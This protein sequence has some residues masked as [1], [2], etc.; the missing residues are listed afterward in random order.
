MTKLEA[1]KITFNERTYTFGVHEVDV[2]CA[3]CKITPYTLATLTVDFDGSGAI[4]AL[5]TDE[6]HV[7]GRL[8]Q[9][10]HYLTSFRPFTDVTFVI[11]SGA[12]G[13][14]TFW[15]RIFLECFP[16]LGGN[17]RFSMKYC[18]LFGLWSSHITA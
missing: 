17:G 4:P 3:F 7:S 15:D 16:G 10:D 14:T 11:P 2:I 12:V 13:R 9:L 5:V 8:R 6:V 1:L 18:T